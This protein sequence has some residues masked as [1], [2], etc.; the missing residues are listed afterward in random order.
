MAQKLEHLQSKEKEKKHM[1]TLW[2]VTISIV[3][4]AVAIAYVDNFANLLER[5]QKFNPWFNPWSV[6][7]LLGIFVLYPFLVWRDGHSQVAAYWLNPVYFSGPVAHYVSLRA[8]RQPPQNPVLCLWGHIIGVFHVFIFGGVVFGTILAIPFLA[9][10][11][12]R[13]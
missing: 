6:G 1:K 4:I 10:G 3:V 2:K 7:S 13:G 11:W 8:E 9:F 12:W 5:V